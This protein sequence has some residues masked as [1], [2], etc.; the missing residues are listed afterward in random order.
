MSPVFFNPNFPLG[1]LGGREAVAG[2]KGLCTVGN[3]EFERC[4]SNVTE[5]SCLRRES[6]SAK[7]RRHGHFASC[8]YKHAAIARALGG[9]RMPPLHC[10]RIAQLTFWLHLYLKCYRLS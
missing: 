9:G 5:A 8:L 4:A 3:G 10:S 2:E 7:Q 6:V 1:F